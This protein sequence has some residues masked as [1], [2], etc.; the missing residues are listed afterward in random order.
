PQVLPAGVSAV[1]PNIARMYSFWTGGKDHLESDRQAAGVLVQD[2]PEVAAIASAN[3]RVVTRA[4]AHAA[5][6]GI[7]QFLDIGAGLPTWPAVHRIA[8]EHAP[9]AKVAYFDNDS[10]VLAH[11]RAL[12]AGPGVLVEHADLRY[13]REIVANADLRA[14][15]DF[16]QPVC[17]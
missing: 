11:A 10:V 8:A 13:P 12:Y 4:V 2:F 6:Q 5:T 1:V 9:A 17:L 14:V 3:R 7:T 16:S 15:I